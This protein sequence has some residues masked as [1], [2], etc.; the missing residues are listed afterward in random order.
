M[1]SCACERAKSAQGERSPR[2][3]NIARV[4]PLPTA[5]LSAVSAIEGAKFWWPVGR[6]AK[7]AAAFR[8]NPRID[9]GIFGFGL[10]PIAGV[11]IGG[12]DEPKYARLL[13]SRFTGAY[14]RT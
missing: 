13:S 1:L 6:G 9:V 14:S 7:G 5:R 3:K 2:C 10:R 8:K 12:R 4:A 11:G